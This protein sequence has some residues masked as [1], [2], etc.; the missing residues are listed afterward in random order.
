MSLHD[1]DTF[2]VTGASGFLGRRLVKLLL[3][4]G[5]R[6]HALS[7]DPGNRSLFPEKE[8]LFFVGDILSPEVLREAARGCRGIF[9][10]AAYARGWAPDEE[11]YIEHNVGGTENV[12][13]AAR[14]AGVPRILF[15]ST[16]GVINPSAGDPAD[17]ETP[18]TLPYFTA[19]ER[20]KARA[21]ALIAE[22]V[23]EGQDIVI[24]NPSRVYGPGPLTESNSVTRIIDLFRRGKWH[25]IPGNGKSYGNYVYVDD[26]AHGMI[27][28]MERGT[29]GRRYIL[30]GENLTYLDLF[31][32]LREATGRKPFLV[33]LPLP[34]MLATAY[35]MVASHRVAGLRPLITPEWVRR[36]MYHWKLNI[37][38]AR[39]ELGYAPLT[40]REGL[41]RT[42]QWLEKNDE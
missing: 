2:L 15:C 34:L 11:I 1:Y 35:T 31:A 29:P 42:L 37:S 38:R 18:R 13:Q 6:V 12:L 8:V 36:Y 25:I 10:L 4:Q 21:E 17:E 16:A 32:R 19:Y 3:R 33:P 28:A 24:V 40:F 23:K 39:N 9:H 27:L 5:Y 20:S 41:E 26:V 7:R 22:Y 30:G 14:A